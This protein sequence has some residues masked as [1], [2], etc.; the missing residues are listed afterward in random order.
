M[1]PNLPN[2]CEL[3]YATFVASILIWLL[4]SMSMSHCFVAHMGIKRENVK[5]N[6]EMMDSII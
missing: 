4:Y 3:K 2:L 6:V 1:T 5:S